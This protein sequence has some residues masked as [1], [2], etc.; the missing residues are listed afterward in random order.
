MVILHSRSP[1]SSCS[2]SSSE[3]PADCHSL[4]ASSV[5]PACAL[6]Q[7]TPRQ[8]TASTRYVTDCQIT[9]DITDETIIYYAAETDLTLTCKTNV[10][11]DAVMG[12]PY[13]A[14]PRFSTS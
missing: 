7:T 12:D 11:S 8:V 4:A 3:P 1:D 2:E 5:L 13:A 9:P 6:D 10:T 14:I